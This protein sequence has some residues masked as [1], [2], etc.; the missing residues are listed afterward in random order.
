MSYD[1]LHEKKSLSARFTAME[2]SCAAIPVHT[3]K[4]V[5]G[6]PVQSGLLVP[7]ALDCNRNRSSQF[8]KLQKPRPNRNR[9]VFCG[10]LQLQDWF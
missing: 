10:L 6:S 4:V 7:S 5:F 2:K 8:E 9:P 1:A 3:S